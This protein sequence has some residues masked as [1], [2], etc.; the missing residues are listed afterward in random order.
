M[1][2]P[3]SIAAYRDVR[4]YISRLHARILQEAVSYPLFVEQGFT[5]AELRRRFGDLGKTMAHS[6]LTKRRCELV[7]AGFIEATE[8]RRPGETKSDMIVW[9]LTDRV[10]ELTHK[11]SGL[12]A[13]PGK[14]FLAGFRKACEIITELDPDSAFAADF[15]FEVLKERY[16]IL[17]LRDD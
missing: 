12:T 4:P 1:N 11:I 10:P 2:R 5:D 17:G 3:T 15:A 14:R 7:R 8:Y 9:Q 16:P 13:G 6:T